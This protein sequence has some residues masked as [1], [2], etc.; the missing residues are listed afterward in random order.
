M[1]VVV[2]KNLGPKA[3]GKELRLMSFMVTKVV[4]IF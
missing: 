2:N 1:G 4:C 3:K